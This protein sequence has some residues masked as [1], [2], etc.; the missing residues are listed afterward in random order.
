M[1]SSADEVQIIPYYSVQAY[2]QQ[3]A[4]LYQQIQAI[5]L[6]QR[7]EAFSGAFLGQPYL[8]GA[9][10]EGP[11][12]YFDQS[13]LYRTDAFDC[14]TFVNTVIALSLSKNLTEFKRNIVR[15][16]YNNE[17]VDFVTRHHFFETD[18]LEH[19][20]HKGYV[21]DITRTI[22]GREQQP[23]AHIAKTTIDKPNWFRHLPASRLHFLQPVS[24][25]L[26]R[27]RLEE[28]HS[29]DKLFKAQNNQ[30]PYLPLDSL[31]TADGEPIEDYFEQ[32]PSGAI[33]LIVRP[34]WAIEE[35]IGTRMNVSHLGFALRTVKKDL[36]FREASLLLQQV[37][38][39]SL[40]DY[41]K[42]YRNSETIK[43]IN[44]QNI[45]ESP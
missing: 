16:G 2:D 35:K 31:F 10:G 24:S 19:N 37:V 40:V 27:Q 15:I 4:Q 11:G 1:T 21:R 45:L 29:Q 33:V 34:D 32:I 22:V 18:W 23:I 14:V 38:D 42:S 36:I 43:G 9:L 5:S 3:I 39:V 8:D 25:E 28:L 44:I 26:V 20:T 6:L 13:P 17:Q 7:L 12:A 41:L 30:L